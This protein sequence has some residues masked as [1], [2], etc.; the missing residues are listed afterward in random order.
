[1]WTCHTHCLQN[2]GT[3]EHE[4]SSSNGVVLHYVE[5]SPS[6]VQLLLSERV[7][8]MYL[9]CIIKAILCT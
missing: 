5:E 7:Q 9:A 8:L 2:M 1:M 4:F 6:A 3:H